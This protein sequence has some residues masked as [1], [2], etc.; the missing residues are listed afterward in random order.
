M[1]YDQWKTTPPDDEP[2]PGEHRPYDDACDCEG[3]QEDAAMLDGDD[4]IPLHE[5]EDLARGESDY[6][7]CP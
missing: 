7:D 3:C 2:A 6:E 5:A 1:T 4:D